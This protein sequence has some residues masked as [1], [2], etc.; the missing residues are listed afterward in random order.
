MPLHLGEQEAGV[1]DVM[2]C[3]DCGREFRMHEARRY[4]ETHGFDSGPFE[5]WEGCPVCGGFF[6]EK[7]EFADSGCE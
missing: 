6:E 1:G 4:V 2:A 7:P 5:E 3:L